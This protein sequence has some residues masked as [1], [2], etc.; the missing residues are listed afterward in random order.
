MAD[1]M[2]VAR[3][4]PTATLLDD[5]RV[6][7]AG[8]ATD[9]S[10]EIYDPRSGRFARTRGNMQVAGR[11]QHT[12]TLLRD[13]RVLIAGGSA[14]DFNPNTIALASAELFN[15]KTETFASIGNM[16]VE[17]SYH[18]AT[19]LKSGK[20]LIVGGA[21]RDLKGIDSA[22]LFDPTTSTFVVLGH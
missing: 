15:P 19:L 20:V 8:G 16:P 11:K 5:G 21:Q 10:A 17:R 3:H 22:L 13:G 4:G 6:L 18:T 9:A 14:S 1:N 7:I 12:A 2:S